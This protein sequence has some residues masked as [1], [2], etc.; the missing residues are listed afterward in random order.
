MQGKEAR[1]RIKKGSRVTKPSAKIK[2]VEC[3]PRAHELKPNRLL[4]GGDQP[5]RTKDQCPTY[6]FYL[7]NTLAHNP[8]KAGDVLG[9]GV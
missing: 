2:S 3:S 1:V 5:P 4:G 8:Q 7:Y 6:Q 9:S